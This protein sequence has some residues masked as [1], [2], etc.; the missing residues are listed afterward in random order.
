MTT[1]EI[2]KIMLAVFLAALLRPVVEAS[3]PSKEIIRSVAV[4]MVMLGASYGI[5]IL[6]LISLMLKN[7]PIDKT[8]IFTVVFF[9]AILIFNLA[10]D[11]FRQ[12]FSYQ[13]KFIE[14][15]TTRVD[16]LQDAEE[17][18]LTASKDLSQI[19]KELIQFMRDN[20]RST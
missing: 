18:H 13:N 1:N 10:T 5:P 8:F 17:N 6:F 4:K 7:A 19:Q 11:Y 14:Q 12:R 3:M 16:K 2:I 15:L 20:E 9:T